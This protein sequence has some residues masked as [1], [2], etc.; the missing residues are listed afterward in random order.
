MPNRLTTLLE[1]PPSSRTAA[2]YETVFDDFVR[3]AGGHRLSE[4]VSIPPGRL[5]ADYHFEFD[6]AEIILELKQVNA[7]RPSR[8]VDEYFAKLIRDGSMR[9]FETLPD[10]RARIS[11]NSLND[12]Q[13]HSFYSTFRSSV[14]D[15]LKTAARQLKSTHALLPSHRRRRI[16]GVV[17]I[18]SGD[19]N[20][21]TD[22]LLRLV[23]WWL[24][25]EWKMGRCGS[26]EF[27][28][29]HAIDMVRDGQNPLYARH[30][31]RRATDEPAVAALRYLHDRWVQ[32]GAD[33]IGATV[34][35]LEG[36]VAD[37]ATP[38]LSGR[39]RGK[40]RFLPPA[41]D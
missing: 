22:L 33:A 21:P 6:D 13:W 36:A 18:N 27:V 11:P 15:H 3:F 32:Y 28:R 24:K 10:G 40:I 4:C 34:E 2:H 1:M 16:Q 17:L 35:F 9:G 39:F 20:L 31:A 26:I 8:T 23:E 30:I 41:R 38:D 19:F 5:N 25:R 7:Y 29:C 37:E 14:S 12:R